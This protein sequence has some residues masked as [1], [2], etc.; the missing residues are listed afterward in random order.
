M[1]KPTKRY[2]R[3]HQRRAPGIP[4]HRSLHDL[5]RP[6]TNEPVIDI[7]GLAPECVSRRA[8][9][10]L[11]LQAR[12]AARSSIVPFSKHTQPT[13]KAPPVL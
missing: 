13:L 9:L 3:T 6:L 2:L 4:R 12:R 5:K 11:E 10:L 8:Q 1:A 7:A